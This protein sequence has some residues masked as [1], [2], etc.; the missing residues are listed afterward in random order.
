MSIIE[1]VLPW[2]HTQRI[3]D[4]IIEGIMKSWDTIQS[5]DMTNDTE[6][7][8]AIKKI[9]ITIKFSFMNNST[10]GHFIQKANE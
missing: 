8:Q 5:N 2:V 3:I 7:L 1:S 9:I 6:P 4:D 10:G